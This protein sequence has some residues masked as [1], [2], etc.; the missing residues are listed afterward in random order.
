MIPPWLNYVNIDTVQEVFRTFRSQF[1]CWK[2]FRNRHDIMGKTETK[3]AGIQNGNEDNVGR[4]NQ[5]A[6][7]WPLKLM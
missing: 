5:R 1:L 3:K 6:Q 4:R 7:C 2:P